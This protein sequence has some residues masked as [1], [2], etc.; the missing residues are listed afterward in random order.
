MHACMHRQ[1]KGTTSE[2]ITSHHTA[3][4]VTDPQVG[5]QLQGPAI[6]ASTEA[7]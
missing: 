7:R 5:N 4:L 1:K 3:L 6:P 2:V